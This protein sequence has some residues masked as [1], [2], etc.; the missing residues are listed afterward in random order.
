MPVGR[1]VHVLVLL[2]V[3]AAH[4]VGKRRDGGHAGAGRDDGDAVDSAGDQLGL[5][6]VLADRAG[7]R[8]EVADR[9]GR[10]QR[11]EEDED[12]VGRAGVASS[13]P[14]VPA[15]WMTMPL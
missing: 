13:A 10:G 2:A 1:H 7:D 3:G 9:E 8:D 6:E 11:V 15:V 4:G 12:A 5:A 14:P